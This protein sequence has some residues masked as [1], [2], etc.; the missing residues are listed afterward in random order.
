VNP[1][2]PSEFPLS[3]RVPGWTKRFEAV[4]GKDR[5]TGTPGEFLTISRRDA[6]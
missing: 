3:L 1:E 6:E 2:K 5:K 4:A